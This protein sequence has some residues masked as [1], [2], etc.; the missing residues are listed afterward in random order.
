MYDLD[1][2]MN[3]PGI[4]DT[5]RHAIE[6]GRIWGEEFLHDPQYDG[7]KKR[8]SHE[9]IWQS[10]WWSVG[11]GVLTGVAGGLTA[12]VGVPTD[13][14]F[15]LYSQ[16]K[17]AAALFAIYEID[18][19][20]PANHPL[21]IAAAAGVSLSELANQLGTQVSKV[22]IQRALMSI[23]GRVFAEI[24]KTLGIKLISKAGEKTMVNVA[25][26]MPFIGSV[27]GGTF[28]G[29]MMNACGGSTTLFIQQW[30]K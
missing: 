15:S 20:D 4:A 10:T 1:A 28:N 26:L 7:D 3:A 21:V 13:I 5:I 27:V 29:V 17:L 16:I 19:N 8:M 24:N 23:P 2:I 30:Q 25:K 9:A 18:T 12:I 6:S 14:A 22:A 11:S